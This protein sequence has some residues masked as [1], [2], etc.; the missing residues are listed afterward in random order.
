M[1]VK[2]NGWRTLN[3]K[4]RLPSAL[5]RLYILFV[6]WIWVRDAVLSRGMGS[7]GLSRNKSTLPTFFYPMRVGLGFARSPKSF[8]KTLCV[9]AARGYGSS[10][11]FCES[12]AVCATSTDGSIRRLSV[13]VPHLR[14]FRKFLRKF[15]RLSVVMAPFGTMVFIPFFLLSPEKPN[16]LFWPTSVQKLSS[17]WML[18]L[19]HIQA[20]PK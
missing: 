9:L 6:F 1:K 12:S 4:R 8:C 7:L 5:R 11:A 2:K 17:H 18:S 20:P 14:K 15:H 13:E 10:A 19:P 16:H 3:S